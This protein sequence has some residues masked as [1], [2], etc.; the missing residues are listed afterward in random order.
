MERDRPQLLPEDLNP[1]PILAIRVPE[2]RGVGYPCDW[3]QS[4][5]L[6]LQT[7]G[8]RDL[9]AGQRQP[10]PQEARPPPPAPVDRVAAPT[11]AMPAPAPVDRIAA[12]PAMPASALVDRVAAAPPAMP[13]SAPVSHVAAPT[14]ATPAP[15]LVDRLAAAPPATPASAPADRVATSPPSPPVRASTSN[16]CISNTPRAELNGWQGDDPP[17]C[18]HQRPAPASLLSCRQHLSRISR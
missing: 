6:P 14:P 1:E 11:P 15:A 16:T 7:P 13:A 4:C 12:P 17:R 8:S 18:H 9:I 2:G 3:T 5:G 10:V